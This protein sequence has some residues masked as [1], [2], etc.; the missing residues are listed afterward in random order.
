MKEQENDLITKNSYDAIAKKYSNRHKNGGTFVSMIEK[1]SEYLPKGGVI[2][3]AG[4][5]HGR[6]TSELEKRGFR[7][8]GIDYSLEMLRLSVR[9]SSALAL[10]M[11][12]RHCGFANC[13]FDGIWANSSIHHLAATDVIFALKEFYRILKPRGLAFISCRADLSDNWD[14]E[15][16]GYPRYYNNMTSNNLTNLLKLASFGI[17]KIEFLRSPKSNKVWF[18]IFSTKYESASLTND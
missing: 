2:L 4:C 10:Q 12:I 8:I 14:K 7:T 16:D 3:D 1:F 6:D 13:L 15:Y 18:C 11:D 9:N 17:D 5:G